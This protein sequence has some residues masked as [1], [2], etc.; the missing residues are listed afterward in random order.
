VIR[1]DVKLAPGNSGG[2]LVDAA[3]AVIGINT[4]IIG[5]DLGLAI[6]SHIVSGFISQMA[7]KTAKSRN[8]RPRI[9]QVNAEQV[10]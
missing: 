10:V 7:G 9:R 6:P 4:M 8:R 3:G 1:S 5:G 2:P